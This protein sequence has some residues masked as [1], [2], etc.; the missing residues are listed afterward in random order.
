MSDK[1]TGPA[2]AAA[3]IV[4]AIVKDVCRK[5]DY[6]PSQDQIDSS[7]LQIEA[8]ILKHCP[9]DKAAGCDLQQPLEGDVV[10]SVTSMN[11][12]GTGFPHAEAIK[13]PED[14]AVGK[15]V[16]ACKMALHFPSACRFDRRGTKWDHPNNRPDQSEIIR[17]LKSALAD[18][19]ATK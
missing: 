11:T 12:D 14:K 15:L 9:E 1:P 16:E 19:E 7:I 10:L 3:E 8:I 5:F 18:Y 17:T 6:Y 4:N 13:T 2:A